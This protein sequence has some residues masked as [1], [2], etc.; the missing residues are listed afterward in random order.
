LIEPILDTSQIRHIFEAGCYPEQ[1]PDLPAYSTHHL[2]LGAWVPEL[3]GCFPL[4][5]H[6]D[7]TE[8]HVAFMP[9]FRGKFAIESAKDAFRW[10][11]DNTSYHVIAADIED[12][13]VARFA[14]SCGMKFTGTRYEVRKW[15]VL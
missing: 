9:E 4:N 3:V 1:W 7:C 11:W 2:V 5:F 12:P 8:I 10:V 6:I 15:A 14:E 13:H